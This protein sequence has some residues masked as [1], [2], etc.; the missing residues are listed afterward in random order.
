MNKELEQEIRTAL[1]HWLLCKKDYGL[2]KKG[3]YYWLEML[4]N[5]DM[6]GRS[7][8]VKDCI[9]YIPFEKFYDIFVLSAEKV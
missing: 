6:C 1:K 4:S 2:F 9:I 7:D 5:G 3:E 8:N